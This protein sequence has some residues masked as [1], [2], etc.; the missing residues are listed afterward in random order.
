[1]INKA[2]GETSLIIGR[3]QKYVCRQAS[4]YSELTPKARI[5]VLRICT[6]LKR[7][8]A[9]VLKEKQNGNHLIRIHRGEIRISSWK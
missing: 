5:F 2:V 4:H 6:L 1:M 8:L 9:G 7:K 3:E